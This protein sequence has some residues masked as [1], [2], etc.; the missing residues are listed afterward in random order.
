MP[1]RVLVNSRRSVILERGAR[2][3]DDSEFA[4]AVRRNWFKCGL[5]IRN[6]CASE[7]QFRG[8]GGLRS[9]RVALI[10][11]PIKIE[12]LLHFQRLVVWFC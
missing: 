8:F 1:V 12:N 7:M 5:F 9:V 3:Y 11:A 10:F 4:V 2:G 6:F